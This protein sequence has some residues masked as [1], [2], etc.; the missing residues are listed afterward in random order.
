MSGY[1]T[2]RWTLV[3]LHTVKLLTENLVLTKDTWTNSI[4]SV[5]T[6]DHFHSI[7]VLVFQS[8][9]AQK[10]FL[11]AETNISFARKGTET[12]QNSFPIFQG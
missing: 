7:G 12:K 3:R 2:A 8:T 4:T 9:S 6:F 5:K 1:T 10:N 11:S